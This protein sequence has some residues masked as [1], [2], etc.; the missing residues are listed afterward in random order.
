[1]PVTE[2]ITIP[3]SRAAK[4][5]LC[6]IASTTMPF[7]YGTVNVDT[8]LMLEIVAELRLVLSQTQNNRWLASW[9]VMH[10][11]L[12]DVTIRLCVVAPHVQL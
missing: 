1:M 11:T 6:P 4:Y 8:E 10:N 5:N 3:R 12:D 9:N 2:Y 7:V